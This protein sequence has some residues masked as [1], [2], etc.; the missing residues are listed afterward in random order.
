MPEIL[1]LTPTPTDFEHLF[2]E[3]NQRFVIFA[4]SF[5]H[6]QMI[7]EDI[8]SDCFLLFWER[9]ETLH[10]GQNIPAYILITIKRRC[11]NWL[12]DQS[13]RL[14]IRQDIH[15][16]G[17]RVIRSRIDTLETCDPDLLYARE[18]TGIIIRE[19]GL[20]PERMRKIFIARRFE[21][22]TYKEIAQKLGL[23]NTQ[24]DYDLHKANKRL[25]IALKDYLLGSAITK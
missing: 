22:M 11:L 7:A 5:V 14:R 9:R 10:T 16:A 6:N 25:L 20:M 3:Y 18:I 15:S 13:N 24:I 12:R 4:R 2:T 1:H 8:V 17:G 21:E 23:T 19:I